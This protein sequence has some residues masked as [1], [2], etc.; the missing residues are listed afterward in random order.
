MHLKKTKVIGI[1]GYL[2]ILKT[3]VKRH[4]SV[5]RA[6]PEKKKQRAHEFIREW[7]KNWKDSQTSLLEQSEF[8][9]C[10]HC[11]NETQYLECEYCC[12]PCYPVVSELQ[13][14]IPEDN[15]G[16]IEQSQLN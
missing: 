15:E 1:T 2:H 7:P 10:Q 16:T 9:V 13:K 4:S 14:D 6:M 11:G 5:L 3:F 12:E 8:I